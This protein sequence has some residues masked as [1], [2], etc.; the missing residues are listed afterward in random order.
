MARVSGEKEFLMRWPYIQ[1]M[2]ELR[3]E[4]KFGIMTAVTMRRAFENMGRRA[5]VRRGRSRAGVF[6]HGS[7]TPP[8]PSRAR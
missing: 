6:A 7:N 2:R 4:T 1:Y 8:P 5:L 3:G